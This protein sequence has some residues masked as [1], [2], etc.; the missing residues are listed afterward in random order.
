[1][2][3]KGE[4]RTNKWIQ[5]HLN[6]PHD[7][8]CLVWPFA[9]DKHGRG[10]MQHDGVQWWAHRYM[11]TLVNGPPPT[12]QHTAA[13]GCGNGHGG[14]VN[15]HHLSW[16]TQA[17]NLEDCRQHGTLVRHH[18]GNVRRVLP[19]EVRAIKD[20]RGFQTQGQLAAKF[21][22]SEGTISDIWH[23]RSHTGESR[24]NHWTE[25]E[26][27]KLKEAFDQGCSIPQAAKFVGRSRA[28]TTAHTY[29]IGLKSGVP[30]RRKKNIERDWF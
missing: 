25:E 17:E 3:L 15:P 12:P 5:A 11:C 28:A 19:E 30:P 21:G 13:H 27:A 23:G 14:C 20:A 18:G 9:R 22:V 16:K 10:M 1:M 7:D 24:I 4:G 8:W 29:R 26:D 2:A 6:Y